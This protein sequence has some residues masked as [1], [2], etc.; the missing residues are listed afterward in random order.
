MTMMKMMMKSAKGLNSCR[1]MNRMRMNGRALNNCFR[2]RAQNS[3]FRMMKSEKGRNRSLCF[4]WSGMVCMKDLTAAAGLLHGVPAAAVVLIA[5][6]W[7]T[8]A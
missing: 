3:F 8:W 1:P 5:E 2:K 4:R 7:S 6:G